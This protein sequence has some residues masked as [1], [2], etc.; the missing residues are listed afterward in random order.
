MSSNVNQL[1]NQCF[2]LPIGHNICWINAELLA[3]AVEDENKILIINLENGNLVETLIVEDTISEIIANESYVYIILVDG[4]VLKMDESFR[5]I[6][7]LDFSIP[8]NCSQV[9]LYKNYI[10]GK[11]LS[12]PAIIFYR[13]LGKFPGKNQQYF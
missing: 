7:P 11:S 8:S 4:T 3:C 2:T 1:L 6:V 12:I 13:D 5:S 10:I 9:E